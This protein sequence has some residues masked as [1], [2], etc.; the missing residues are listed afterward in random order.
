MQELLLE[1]LHDCQRLWGSEDCDAIKCHKH[2]VGH[3]TC[4]YQSQKATQQL[5]T[6]VLLYAWS[7]SSLLSSVLA[8]CLQELHALHTRKWQGAPV[9]SQG[10]GLANLIRRMRH[11]MG[12]PLNLLAPA[13]KVEKRNPTGLQHHKASRAPSRRV[14]RP[15]KRW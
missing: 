8:Y 9:S 11:D 1:S 2:T 13:Q 3:Y 15:G 12:E 4:S 14:P 7:K 10:Y 6:G 5:G